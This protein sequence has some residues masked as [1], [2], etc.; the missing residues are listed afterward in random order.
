[1]AG[2]AAEFI[3]GIA[4]THGF[5]SFDPASAVGRSYSFICEQQGCRARFARSSKV[6][7]R[8][9][10]NRAVLA[11]GLFYEPISLFKGLA[12]KSRR[13][14]SE[15]AR[16]LRADRAPEIPLTFILAWFGAKVS[17]AAHP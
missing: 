6:Q 9:H 14:L 2:V 8:Q 13:A 5:I 12:V 3:S 11:M 7:A 1:V 10:C 15:L 17:S 16:R 4:M